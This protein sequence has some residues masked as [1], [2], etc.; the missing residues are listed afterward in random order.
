MGL[1]LGLGRLL[2]IEAEKEAKRRSR[3]AAAAIVFW[4]YSI[5]SWYLCRRKRKRTASGRYSFSTS[6]MVTKFLS[7]LLILRPSICRWPECRE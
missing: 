7:D 3:S 4:L 2:E 1:G 6:R 5:G